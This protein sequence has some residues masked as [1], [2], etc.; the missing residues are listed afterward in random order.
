MLGSLTELST[1][2]GLLSCRQRLKDSKYLTK[3]TLKNPTSTDHEVPGSNI[4]TGFE[5]F[6]YLNKSAGPAFF[7]T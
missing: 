4:N 3:N 6:A 5:W 7:I 2:Q 1:K